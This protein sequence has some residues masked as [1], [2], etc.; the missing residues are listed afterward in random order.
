MPVDLNPLDRLQSKKKSSMFVHDDLVACRQT[1]DVIGGSMHRWPP[2]NT[3]PDSEP[4]SSLLARTRQAAGL[5]QSALARRAHCSVATISNAE[6]GYVPGD[7]I[8]RNID[9]ALGTGTL[10]TDRATVSAAPSQSNS[11]GS[12]RMSASTGVARAIYAAR[13][14]L[15]WSH[16]TLARRAFISRSSVCKYEAAKR[17]PSNATA[18]RLD[19][20]LGTK[21]QVQRLVLLAHARSRPQH[22]TQAPPPC[23]LVGH[24]GILSR[25][26]TV[27]TNGDRPLIIKT[28]NV[29]DLTDEQIAAVR[30]QTT[31]PGIDQIILVDD[32]QPARPG[33]V[34]RVLFNPQQQAVLAEAAPR[35]LNEPR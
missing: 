14:A 11:W 28:V 4:L 13:T 8:M 33:T 3:E 31:T 9:A 17:T 19:A 32:R 18:E 27:L 15:G 26:A 6:N 1:A 5:S 10:L 34:P 12:D 25:L 35:T 20:A 29:T 24:H 7:D 22:A 16:T 23:P 2:P 21:G 30:D